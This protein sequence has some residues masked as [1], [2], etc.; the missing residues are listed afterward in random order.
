M[1]TFPPRLR[2]VLAL[3]RL[4]CDRGTTRGERDTAA[5]EALREVEVI[6]GQAEPTYW[7]PTTIMCY[8]YCAAC[9]R[10]IRPLMKGLV[11]SDRSQFKHAE[12]VSEGGS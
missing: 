12:C 4:A 5:Q 6:L 2:R 10:Q 9:G 11:N 8:G 3:L 1:T 7:S